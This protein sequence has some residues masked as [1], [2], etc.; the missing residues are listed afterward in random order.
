MRNLARLIVLAAVIAGGW[1][2]FHGA[3][4]SFGLFQAD[5]NQS[6]IVHLANCASTAVTA[7]AGD[8]AP[9]TIPAWESRDVDNAFWGKGHVTRASRS[10]YPAPPIPAELREGGSA[11]LFLQIDAQSRLHLAH[12]AGCSAPRLSPQPAGFPIEPL[13][14]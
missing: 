7:G 8:S 3:R 14:R 10:D 11:T 1:F 12:G 2:A 4:S 6:V 9:F 5:R 13:A